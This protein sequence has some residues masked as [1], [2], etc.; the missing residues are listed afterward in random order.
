[1]KTYL[2]GDCHSSRVWEEYL[3]SQKIWTTGA[4]PKDLDFVAWGKGGLSAMSFNPKQLS[5]NNKRSS[6]IGLNNSKDVYDI[7]FNDLD[8]TE[9]I[10]SKNKEY[11]GPST[12]VMI[13]LG[14][15]DIKNNL[16]AFN[17]CDNVVSSYVRNTLEYFNQSNVLFIEPFPQFKQTIVMPNEPSRTFSYKDRKEQNDIFIEYLNKEKFKRKNIVNIITQKEILKALGM[18]E[19]D[20]SNAKLDDFSDFPLDGLK[21]E[22]YKNILDLFLKKS[23][24]VK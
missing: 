23:D 15:I 4:N 6:L 5:N 3:K 1:M 21:Q 20:I 9:H 13:W 2:I 10:R 16:P 14:Y 22:Y 8:T 11:V 17:N 24:D 19:L 7:N 12:T 18:E